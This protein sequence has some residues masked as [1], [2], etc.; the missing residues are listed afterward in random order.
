MITPLR[1]RG[2][3]TS[4][5]L[6]FSLSVRPSVRNQYFCHICSAV[7]AHIHLKLG[8]IHQ[9]G[10]L[11]VAYLIQVRQSSTFS[12]PTWDS[13]GILSEYKLTDFLPNIE[14]DAEIKDDNL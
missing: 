6:S 7:I 12:F 3:Y 2:M 10:T 13:G 11:H 1:R 14:V 8:M 5:P 4:L 9:V